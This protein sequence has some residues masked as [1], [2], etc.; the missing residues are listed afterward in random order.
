MRHIG[1]LKLLIEQGKVNVDSKY[2]QTLLSW[3]VRRGDKELVQ[4]L[5]MGK[6]NKI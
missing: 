2:N 6:S 5:E 3:A 1:V 4:L